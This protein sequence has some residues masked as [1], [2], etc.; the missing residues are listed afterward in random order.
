MSRMFLSNARGQL[1]LTVPFV[2]TSA[3]AAIIR[4]NCSRIRVAEDDE[5]TMR[6]AIAGE[7]SEGE[8]E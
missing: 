4:S 3:H 2:P 1:P 8:W 5:A 7:E 6:F